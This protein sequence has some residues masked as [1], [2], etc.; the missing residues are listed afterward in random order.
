MPPG[1]G[2]PAH[3]ALSWAEGPTPVKESS[4]HSVIPVGHSPEPM[5]RRRAAMRPNRKTKEKRTLNYSFLKPSA[6]LCVLCVLNFNAEDAKE[7]GGKERTCSPPRPQGKEN[8][9]LFNFILFSLCLC[10]ESFLPLCSRL[11]NSGFLVNL[12]R[13]FCGLKPPTAGGGCN[14]AVPGE[15]P[16]P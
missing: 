10:G 1:R 6:V 5:M 12:F 16:A 15:G 9:K 11:S 2:C 8:I 7:R 13:A 4:P 14:R 3:P